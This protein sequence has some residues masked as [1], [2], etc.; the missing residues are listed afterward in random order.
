[1]S[2]KERKTKK[3]AI[4]D[5]KPKKEVNRFP[6]RRERAPAGELGVRKQFL[7]AVLRLRSRLRIDRCRLNAESYYNEVERA[8]SKGR[9]AK[10]ESGR[11]RFA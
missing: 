3:V 7:R 11:Y 10:G 1:M 2:K 8:K 6:S 4:R 9:K 5:L